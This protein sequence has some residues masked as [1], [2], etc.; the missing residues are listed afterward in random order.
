MAIL[1]SIP[2]VLRLHYV[3]NYKYYN[4]LRVYYYNKLIFLEEISITYFGRKNVW[5]FLGKWFH[6]WWFIYNGLYYRQL[7]VRSIGGYLKLSTSNQHVFKTSLVTPEE[8]EEMYNIENDIPVSLSTKISSLRK[9]VKNMV[10]KLYNFKLF[11]FKNNTF[12][13]IEISS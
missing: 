5:H 4:I 11:V 13:A 2:N 1:C 8:I 10:A 7:A 3:S 6:N 12:K 9:K